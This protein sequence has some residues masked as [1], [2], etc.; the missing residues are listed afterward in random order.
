VGVVVLFFS[1]V[2]LVPL[3]LNVGTMYGEWQMTRIEEQQDDLAAEQASL[4]AKAAALS[5]GSRVRQEAERLGMEP[6]PVVSYIVFTGEGAAKDSPGPN[7]DFVASV[8]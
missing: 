8:R 1:L 6:A 2:V 7:G 4:Q 5:S 3:A